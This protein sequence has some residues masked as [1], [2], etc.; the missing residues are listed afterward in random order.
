MYDPALGR[1]RSQSNETVA[2]GS[3]AT[4][5][6]APHNSSGK[7]AKLGACTCS[8]EFIP[9]K[10]GLGAGRKRP[11]QPGIASLHTSE[12]GLANEEYENI[13]G[14]LGFGGMCDMY[15]HMKRNT[16]M[17]YANYYSSDVTK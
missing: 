15:E 8:I 13:F 4:T 16:H 11:F 1:N 14:E 9:P 12:P 7:N 5:V 10:R 3:A 17:I 2:A 6:T